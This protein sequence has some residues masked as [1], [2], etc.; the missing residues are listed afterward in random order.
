MFFIITSKNTTL[1]DYR[2]CSSSCIIC[3]FFLLDRMLL[4]ARYITSLCSRMWPLFTAMAFCCSKNQ[5]RTL[6]LA[7]QVAKGSAPHIIYMVQ[8][9]WL[10]THTHTYI[11]FKTTHLHANLG[12]Q[13]QDIW[14]ILFGC[15]NMFIIELTPGPRFTL[16][17]LVSLFLLQK[18][19][20]NCS[21]DSRVNFIFFHRVSLQK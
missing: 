17:N 8:N 19:C 6:V 9:L 3:V 14:H 16:K 11:W 7:S 4:S 21:F 15:L 12:L 2:I 10:H 13:F 1:S 20:Y 5:I 18:G